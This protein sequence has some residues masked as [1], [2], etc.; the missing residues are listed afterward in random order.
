MLLAIIHNDTN[1]MTMVKGKYINKNMM[2]Q[3]NNFYYYRPVFIT[4]TYNLIS[5]P[6]CYI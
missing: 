1:D 6:E 5:V 2:E 4:Y 3:E